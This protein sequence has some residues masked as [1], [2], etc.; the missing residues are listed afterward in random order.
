MFCKCDI[1]C[2]FSKQIKEN[3]SLENCHISQNEKISVELDIATF[4]KIFIILMLL[5]FTK[6][7]VIY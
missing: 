3:I 4:S 7:N 5:F 1:N 2:S 6:Q